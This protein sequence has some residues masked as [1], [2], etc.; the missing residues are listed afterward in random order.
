MEV[1][2]RFENDKL[3]K[4]LETLRNGLSFKIGRFLTFVPRKIIDFTRK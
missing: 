4:K 2:K 3:K 1:R